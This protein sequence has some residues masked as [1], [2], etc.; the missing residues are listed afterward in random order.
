VYFCVVVAGVAYLHENW[1]LHRDLK[2]SNILL[3]Q[4]RLKIAGVWGGGVRHACVAGGLWVAPGGLGE[5][6]D[7]SCKA[8]FRCIFNAAASTPL[9]HVYPELFDCGPCNPRRRLSAPLLLL[10]LQTLGWLGQCGSHWNRCGPT[11]WWSLSGGWVGGWVGSWAGRQ[12]S[13]QARG[14]VAIEHRGCCS[15]VAACRDCATQRAHRHTATASQPIPFHCH[16]PPT[17][18]PPCCR[19]R[20]R[21]PELLLDARHY[22]GAVDVWAVGCIMAELMLLRPLFQASA[23]GG[24]GG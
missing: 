8:G 19:R 12:A 17:I 16:T 9:R 7:C 22:T 14:L 13:R 24:G 2:P 18:P 10:L 15:I 3:E 4:G 11:G 21:A 5:P 6:Q 23:A 20:Y 1:V